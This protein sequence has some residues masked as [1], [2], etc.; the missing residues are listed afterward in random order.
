MY[1][2]NKS[3]HGDIGHCGNQVILHSRHI[4]NGYSSIMIE[5]H[6]YWLV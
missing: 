4:V 6:K 3:T 2:I 5:K 1:F